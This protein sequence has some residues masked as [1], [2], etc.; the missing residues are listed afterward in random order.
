MGDI[1]GAATFSILPIDTVKNNFFLFFRKFI[2]KEICYLKTPFYGKI[3]VS[4][5]CQHN[6]P[7]P[8]M[9]VKPNTINPNIKT[10]FPSLISRTHE[11]I[12][13]L[14]SSPKRHTN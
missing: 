3:A 7:P 12:D 1:E 2:V 5:K 10:P 4:K 14:H 11:L 13:S 6:Q 8:A 9:R